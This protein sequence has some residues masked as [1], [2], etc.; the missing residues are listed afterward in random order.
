LRAN[1]LLTRCWAQK[2]STIGTM[3]AMRKVMRRS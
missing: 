1:V 2:P 3:N